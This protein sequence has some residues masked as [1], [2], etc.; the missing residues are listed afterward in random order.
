[1]FSLARR[2]DGVSESATLKLNA[3]VQ[4]MK[5]R[6]EDVVLAFD[7]DA[8]DGKRGRCAIVDD[9]GGAEYGGGCSGGSHANDRAMS[10][11]MQGSTL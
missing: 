10:S 7:S 4:A 5:A 1:M 11:D 3:L 9:G 2:L 8:Q 6:G